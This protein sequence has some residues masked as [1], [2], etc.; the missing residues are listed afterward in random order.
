VITTDNS[1]WATNCPEYKVTAVQVMPVAQPSQWQQEF[2]QYAAMQESLL[3]GV[4]ATMT[5]AVVTK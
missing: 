1:D 4:P 2:K 5:D 3:K